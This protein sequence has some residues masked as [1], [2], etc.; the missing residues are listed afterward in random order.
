MLLSIVKALGPGDQLI[1]AQVAEEFRPETNIR[2]QAKF[3]DMP[4][5]LLVPSKRLVVWRQNQARLNAIWQQVEGRKLQITSSLTRHLVG[6]NMAAVTDF[7]GALAYSAQRLS[8]EPASVKYLIIFSDLEHDF[9]EQR[10]SRPPTQQMDLKGVQVRLLYVP[11]SDGWEVRRKEW[12]T[13][14]KQSGAADFLMLDA[15]QSEEATIVASV[16][17]PRLQSPLK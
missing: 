1:V 6:G 14:F 16:P 9:E 7:W 15:G 10:T 5:E 4:S 11:W 2:L 3:P 8:Q 12:A 13:W 17:R